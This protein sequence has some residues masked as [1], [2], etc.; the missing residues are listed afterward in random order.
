LLPGDVILTGTPGGIGPIQSGD[1]LEVRIQ[2][3]APLI[4]SVR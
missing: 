4:N 3:L 1:K 2:G